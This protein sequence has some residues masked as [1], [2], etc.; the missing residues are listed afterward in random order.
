MRGVLTA[1]CAMLFFVSQKSICF[2]EATGKI[3]A[4][5]V[6]VRQSAD[7]NSEVIGSSS[8]GKTVT[9]ISQTT[10][11]SG[12]VWYEVYVDANTTGYIRSD[13]VDVDL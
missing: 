6:K 7:T 9:L 13:L 11:A 5:S 12:Y 1:A 3:K 8:L 4:A 10:D 2:A